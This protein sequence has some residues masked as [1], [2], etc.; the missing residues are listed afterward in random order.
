MSIEYNMARQWLKRY[1]LQ[2]GLIDSKMLRVEVLKEKASSPGSPKLDGMPR[3]QKWNGDG[4]ASLIATY[5]D[6]ERELPEDIKM[7][8]E[9]HKQIDAF[10]KRLKGQGSAEMR[11]VLQMKY[12]DL[13]GW[14]DIVEVLFLGKADFLEKEDSYTR[15]TFKIHQNGITRLSELM[16]EKE[17]QEI[18]DFYCEDFDFPDTESE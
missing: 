1:Q 17:L 16:G 4:L 8:R 10:I 7:G 15:R 3:D 18:V 9:L 11:L 2:R 14:T 13:F 5:T 6:I 12:L